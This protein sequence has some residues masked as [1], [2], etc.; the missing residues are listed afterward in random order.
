MPPPFQ[1]TLRGFHRTTQAKTFD[2]RHQIQKWISVLEV[3][4][5]RVDTLGYSAAGC[6]GP[7]LTPQRPQ[8]TSRVGDS[9][10]TGD[11]TAPSVLVG[12][13]VHHHPLFS[14]PLICSPHPS[15][16]PHLFCVLF[17]SFLSLLISFVSSF[18]LVTRLLS[19]TVE[20]VRFLCFQSLITLTTQ[21][22]YRA[23]LQGACLFA[24]MASYGDTLTLDNKCVVDH[25]LQ[26]PHR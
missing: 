3:S 22:S 21:T 13:T 1:A 5:E 24:A 18:S 8:L 23:E 16:S 4:G 19:P 12:S 11:Y 10:S 2:P 6:W 7:S 9:G 26:H 15:R 20:L 14:P 25:G 17:L